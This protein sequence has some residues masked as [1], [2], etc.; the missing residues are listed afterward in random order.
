MTLSPYRYPGAKTKLLPALM[1]HID[2]TL[3]GH[4]SFCDVFV[5]GGSVLLE[6]AKKYPKIQL[7]VNDKDCGI[8]SFWTVVASSDITKL[9]ELLGMLEVKPTIEQFYKLRETP[10]NTIVE[11]AYRALYFNRTTFSGIATS[12]PI[13]GREQKSKYT[14]DCRYNYQ[15]LKAKILECHQLLVCRTIVD[16]VDANEY[17]ANLIALDQPLYCDPPYY[18][19][20]SMLYPEKMTIEDHTSLAGTL[21]KRNNWILSYDDAPQIRALYKDQEIIDLAAR[22]SI[23]GTKKNWEDKNELIILPKMQ[24]DRV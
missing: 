15:K 18:D 12:G 17:L 13:G 19:K 3:V 16:N 11:R 10:A 21:N 9:N 20:G 1:E 24:G 22:Y 8:S 4:N 23:N 7:L 6:V 2:K 14:V 5:G